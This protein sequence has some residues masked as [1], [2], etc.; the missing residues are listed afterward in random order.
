VIPNRSSVVLTLDFN[1][2]DMH[3]HVFRAL[4]RRESVSLTM[5]R[6]GLKSDGVV[7]VL[8]LRGPEHDDGK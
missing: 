6:I 7:V 5:P 2:L 1:G 3:S 4:E 8:C